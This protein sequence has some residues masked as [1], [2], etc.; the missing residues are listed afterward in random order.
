MPVYKDNLKTKDNRCWYFTD[1]VNGKKYK[2]K[3]YLTK[4]EAKEQERL[5]LSH[6]NIP[7]TEKFEV[8]AE[9][10]FDYLSQTRRDKTLYNYR[11]AYNLHL[12]AYFKGFS[13][14]SI[15][16]SNISVWKQNMVSK[17]Y[18][19]SYLNKL[20]EI[21]KGI[22]DYAI[23]NYNLTLNPVELAGRFESKND[24]VIPDS[25]KIRYITFNDFNKFIF[26]IDNI[27]WKTFFIFLYYTGM[28]KGEVQ[29]LTWND[30]D[31]DKNEIIVNKTLSTRIKVKTTATK[32]NLNRK[33]KISKTLAIQLKEYKNEIMKYTD[34]NNNWFVF[35]CTRF[36]PSS[37]I[38]RY[39]HIYFVKSGVKEITIHEFR[40]SHVSL[41][42]NE[43]IKSGQTDSVK[44]FLM[45]SARMGHSIE[46]MQKTY[47]HLFDSVQD[48]IINLLDNL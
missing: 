41:L 11:S 12:K 48:E 20:Y 29:A 10:Y 22:F 45:M 7:I 23:K 42:I 24:E 40:H 16:V 13:I 47:M 34:F 32:N 5:F 36:L 38:D 4:G 39:K 25:E 3:R 33:V 35:G 15:N 17:H 28:R 27:A 46:V 37:T 31:L 6:V 21:L 30:I 9:G 26:V 14:K 18:K 19:I 2:S 44:F 43:F 8:V 1:Y